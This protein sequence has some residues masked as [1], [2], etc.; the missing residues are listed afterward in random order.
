MDTG[1]LNDTLNEWIEYG[2]HQFPAVQI[3]GVKF[4]GQVNPDNVFEDICMG[5]N[6]TPKGC[7]KFL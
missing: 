7:T 4:R 6:K 1:Y 3:N 2:S 5:F